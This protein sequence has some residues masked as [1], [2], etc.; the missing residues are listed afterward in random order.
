MTGQ[1]PNVAAPRSGN[2]GKTAAQSRVQRRRHTRIAPTTAC[3]HRIRVIADLLPFTGA[4]AAPSSQ[5]Q[6]FRREG[7]PFRS[8]RLPRT[9]GSANGSWTRSWTLRRRAE[10]VP[11][12][13]PA[14]ARSAW[15]SRTGTL[16]VAIPSG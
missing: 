7:R 3:P 14:P 13:D 6:S 16:R 5:A 15:P 2:C 10:V 1:P 8:V 9:T 11:H 12:A 4:A